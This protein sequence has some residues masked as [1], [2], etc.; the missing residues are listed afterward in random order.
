MRYMKVLWRHNDSDM[1]VVLYSEIGDDDMECRKVDIFSDG[2][3]GYAGETISTWTTWLGEVPIPSVPEIAK[4][5]EFEPVEI[6]REE[7]ESIWA[8]AMSGPIKKEG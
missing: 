3:Y 8:K 4:N 2:T 1:P 6:S 7:F 5:P